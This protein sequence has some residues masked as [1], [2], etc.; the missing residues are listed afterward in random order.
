MYNVY[1]V[2]MIGSW[3]DV[4]NAARN[5]V[6]K[7]ATEGEPS[8]KWKFKLARAQHSPIR[9]LVY[10]WK[11]DIPYWLSVHLVRHNVGINHYVTT[12]REDRTDVPRDEKPQGALVT[13]QCSA[14]LETLI[15]MSRKRLC[16]QAHPETRKLWRQVIETLSEIDPIVGMVCVPE[17]I[18]RGGYCP[19]MF[20]S[21]DKRCRWSKSQEAIRIGAYY[22]YGEERM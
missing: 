5:T 11:M 14:N 19:E 1:E 10:R 20:P 17:C 6:S 2:S 3:V 18:Y 9:E 8:N 13:H 21:E 16:T 7:E 4:K 15:N 12:Q 22:M